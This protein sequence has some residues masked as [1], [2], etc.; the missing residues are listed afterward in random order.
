MQWL[1]SLSCSFCLGCHRL[2]GRRVQR[3]VISRRRPHRY[4]ALQFNMLCG[5]G[6]CIICYHMVNS[7]LIFPAGIYVSFCRKYAYGAQQ[8]RGGD[9]IVRTCTSPNTTPHESNA[10]GGLTGKLSNGYNCNV[11]KLS[12]LFV[13]YLGGNLMILI[14]RFI[15]AF[16][17][18]FMRRVAR[19][20]RASLF[21]KWQTPSMKVSISVDP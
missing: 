12:S 11:S 9:S 2:Y 7:L 21:S 18:H 16:V 5:S 14:S 13:R 15:S 6:A 1:L 17:N 8:L 19:E 20:R 4:G 10:L 3:C